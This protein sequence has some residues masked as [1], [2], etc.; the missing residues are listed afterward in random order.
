MVASGSL[1][2]SVGGGG[3]DIAVVAALLAGGVSAA[4]VAAW[5][6]RFL[7]A[8]ALGVAVGGVLFVLNVREL[9]SSTELRAVRWLA[10]G[11]VALAC[12]YAAL[13]PRIRGSKLRLTA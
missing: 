12:G 13:R 3:I 2:A 4:P 5:A 1:V 8:R 11:L 7:P 10:Y 6:I 9:T